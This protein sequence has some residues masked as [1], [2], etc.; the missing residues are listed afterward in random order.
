MG[1][2]FNEAQWLL[3]VE[4]DE[5]DEEG[6]VTFEEVDEEDDRDGER[7]IQEGDELICWLAVSCANGSNCTGLQ[8]GRIVSVHSV[9]D[10]KSSAC[11]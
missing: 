1:V 2:E 3:D 9:K 11:R 10:L 7:D 8:S 6:W 4:E 5:E